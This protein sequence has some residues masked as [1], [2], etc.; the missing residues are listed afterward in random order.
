MSGSS[1]AKGVPQVSDDCNRART[2]GPKWTALTLGSL[3][4]ELERVDEL[5]IRENFVVQVRAR[6]AARRSDET[7]DVPAVHILSDLDVETAQMTVPG[8][9]PEVV[10]E[11]DQVAV[12]A[13]GRRRLD[14]AVRRRVDGLTLFSGDIDA[15][16]IRRFAGERI[17]PAAEIAG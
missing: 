3:G 9:Q 8:R 10:F 5:A 16:M 1:T 2:A 11:R 17:G 4:E 15:L 7:D 6:G 13:R 14:G 12:V